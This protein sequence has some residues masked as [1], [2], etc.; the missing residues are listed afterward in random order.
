[1]SRWLQSG[2]AK[3]TKH[4]YPPPPQTLHPPHCHVVFCRGPPGV[5]GPPGMDGMGRGA[6][7]GGGPPQ[8]GGFF[9]GRGGGMGRGAPPGPLP[10]NYLCRRCSKPGHHIKDCP[11][12]GKLTNS[13]WTFTFSTRTDGCLPSSPPHPPM[14]NRRRCFPWIR[15]VVWR[16]PCLVNLQHLPISPHN[17]PSLGCCCC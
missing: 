13:G 5:T 8:R 17:R 2:H 7:R 15:R 1:M 9:G 11:T 10:P 16:K 3:T 4:P 6:G 14:P 12:N